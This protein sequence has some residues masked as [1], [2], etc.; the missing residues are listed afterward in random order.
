MPMLLIWSSFAFCASLCAEMTSFM[1]LL[2]VSSSWLSLKSIGE[3]LWSRSL[4]L[5]Y[6]LDLVAGCIASLPLVLRLT[7]ADYL[8][9]NLKGIEV[10]ISSTCSLAIWSSWIDK[11]SSRLISLISFRSV[12]WIS[13]SMSKFKLLSWDL[14]LFAPVFWLLFEFSELFEIS[15]GL[16]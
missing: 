8:S 1:S 16:F 7:V 2:S 5:F 15:P 6:A 10:C 9:W 13:I 4:N 11:A 12:F 3:T 14:G